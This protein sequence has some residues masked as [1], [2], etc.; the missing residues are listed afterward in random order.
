MNNRKFNRTAQTPMEVILVAGASTTLATGALVATATTL[1]I[2]D[3]QLGVLSTDVNGTNLANNFITAGA[4]TQQV[5]SVKVLR[6]TPNSDDLTA[7]SPFNLNDQRYLATVDIFPEDIVE[8]STTLPEVGTFSM[9]YLTSFSVPTV[10]TDYDLVITLESSQMDIEYARQRANTNFFS[11]TASN[12]APTAPT[13]EVLQNLAMAANSASVYRGGSQP[14]FVF[15]IDTTAAAG[16][17]INN[18]AVGTAINVMLK[19]GIQTVFTATA[20]FVEALRRTVANTVMVGTETIVNLGSVTPGSAATINALLIVGLKDST[21]VILDEETRKMVKVEAGST[22]TNTRQVGSYAKE[23]VGTGKAWQRQ[24]KHFYGRQHYFENY[25]RSDWSGGIETAPSYITA[26]EAQLYT[27]TRITFNTVESHSSNLTKTIPHVLTILLPATITNP[28]AAVSTPYTIATT[29]ATLVTNLNAS[30]GVWLNS[31]YT[32][33]TNHSY[34]QAATPG[35][36]F[37]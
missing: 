16:T 25:Y 30:L 29:N 7:V 34:Y 3:G 6:G 28:S 23:W 17:V 21:A 19:D 18:V 13:D 5:K 14:Y 20:E 4:T 1:N 15:G 9:D 10:A 12:P 36:V 26:T 22:L 2:A 27:S 11:V 32:L 37:V 24:W 35:A 33:W 31:A 8:I